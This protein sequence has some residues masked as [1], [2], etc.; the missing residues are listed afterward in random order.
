MSTKVF[1]YILDFHGNT[2]KFTKEVGGVEGL[3]KGAAVAAGAMFAADKVMDAAAAVA[4]YAQE[5]SGVRSQVSKLTS[6]QGAALDTMTGQ[7]Q[8]IAQAYDQDMNESVAASNALMKA[9]GENSQSAFNIINSGFATT[10]NANGDFLKQVSEYSIHFRE[11]ELAAS[12]MVAVIAEGNK[13]GVFDD[14]AADAIKEGSIRLREMTNGTRA[15]LNTIGLSADQIQTDISSGNKSMFE[16]MQLVSRQ[17]NSLPQQSPA[18]G[19]ALADIFGGPGEDAVQFIRNLHSINTNLDELVAAGGEATAAQMAWTQELSE[20]HKIGAQVFGGTNQLI[21]GI[22]ATM[23][24]WVNEG[25]KGLVSVTNYF[26]DLYNESTVFR[27]SIEAVRFAFKTMFDFVSSQFDALLNLFS[28]TG[29]VI[30]AIFTGDWNSIGGIVTDTFSKVADNAVEFGSK[31]AENF[32]NAVQQ[33]LTPREKIKLISLSPDEAVQAGVSMAKNMAS[34]FMSGAKDIVMPALAPLNG[35][36]QV[37]GR[38]ED[39]FDLTPKLNVDQILAGSTTWINANNSI[40]ESQQLMMEKQMAVEG[41]LST[42]FSNIGNNII[43]ALGVAQTGF[44]GFV[45]NMASTAIQLISMLTAQAL[46]NA[47]FGAT[48]SAAATGPAA[49]I[50]QPAFIATAVGGV[51]SAF[52]ALPSFATGGVIPGVSFFGD[53]MLARVNSGEEILR[54]DD[55]RHRMNGGANQRGEAPRDRILIG[56]TKIDRGH[57]YIAYEE[58][59][60]DIN[61]LT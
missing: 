18:V 32:S 17:L 55:P 38:E 49:I 19:T 14:K 39:E 27:G 29:Q 56:R 10:A 47:I 35:E 57:I 7:V 43:N 16:V 4:D 60:A 3:L 52:A 53:K 33:T 30:K 1:K 58:A 40:M 28:G 22:K 9:F 13:M 45:A 51:L 48:S 34:G 44:E 11:A 23:M 8:A 46:A 61:K 59:K 42:G 2:Q 26:I 6:A 25:I 41:A 36:L 12:E 20:F 5:I 15:A 50:T 37:S 24:S 54:R 21:T 31:T